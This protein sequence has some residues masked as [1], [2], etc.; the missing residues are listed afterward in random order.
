MRGRTIRHRHL[1]L[2]VQPTVKPLQVFS[3]QIENKTSLMSPQ[4]N[5]I[6]GQVITAMVTPFDA[7]MEVDYPAVS[8]LSKHLM[9]N[10]NDGLV[11]AGTT[12]ESPTLT[13]EEK[14][15]LFKVVK[16]AVG[17]KGSV[18][19]GT[20]S[21]STAATIEFTKE[22][23]AVGVDGVLVVCPYYNKPPQEGLYRH[24]T[25]IAEKTKLP[26]MIYNI[27]GRTGVNMLP[28]T[29]HRLSQIPNIVGIKEAAGSVDQ[30]AEIAKGVRKGFVIWSGDDGLTLPFLS[31]GAVGV[32]SVAAHL[33][34]PEIKQMIDLYFR[35]SVEEA[36]AI[37]F[38]LSD[39]FK[40]IFVTT[41]PI[42]IKAAMKLA[43]F[44]VGGLRLPLVEAREKEIQSLRE[45]MKPLSLLA[46]EAQSA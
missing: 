31:V 7:K 44:P 6:F 43:G 42:L 30:V 27:P 35:G 5:L 45:V 24:F 40:A 19:A 41:S 37:H 29:V 13:H 25:L 20:G 28:E 32:V 36:K 17:S 10:G 18:I 1:V 34:G 22:A 2:F 14:L 38:K 33:V 21:F 23:E 4:K 16:E 3:R 26:I 12:G 9:E 39:F 46:K 8:R 11:V 15:K